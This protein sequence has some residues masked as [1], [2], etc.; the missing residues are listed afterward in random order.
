MDLNRGQIYFIRERFGTGFTEFTKIGRVAESGS[1]DSAKRAQEHQTGNPRL[2][3]PVTVVATA[4]HTKVENTL[5]RDFAHLRIP[6]G[7]WFKL[8]EIN[9]AQAV[10]RCQGLAELNESYVPFFAAATEY[11]A[12]TELAPVLDATDAAF[13]WQRAY[14]LAH[15]GMTAIERIIDQY[16]DLLER[17]NA[18]G[19]DINRY[20]TVTLERG[21]KTF[22][23]KGFCEQHPDLV[24][25]YSFVK[26]EKRGKI[27]VLKLPDETMLGALLPQEIAAAE[28]E[29]NLLGQ[30]KEPTVADLDVMHTS[31]LS[32]RGLQGI[33]E[34]DQN[35]AA[36]H[37]MVLCGMSTGIQS[38][39]SWCTTA[40]STAIDKD[41]L[42]RDHPE[43]W[44][45][46]TSEGDPFSKVTPTKG[47]ISLSDLG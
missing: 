31:Y 25:A 12:S 9:L 1:R 38:V 29:I 40:S 7:V 5:H 32:L 45:A 47:W 4:L 28:I 26:P 33:L 2:L 21:R 17:L 44:A 39:C 34:A 16:K 36:V 10:Q 19:T 43:K 14:R 11:E 41:S 42:K 15:I 27:K 13:E 23:E 6:G 35:I 18:N 3:E 24:T 20:A 8:D 37:L 22:N 30:Q 46:F